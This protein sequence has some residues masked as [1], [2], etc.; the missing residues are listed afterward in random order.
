LGPG[1]LREPRRVGT[2][3]DEPTGRRELVELDLGFD[4][5]MRAKSDRRELQRGHYVVGPH[6]H[7]PAA[8]RLRG[9]SAVVLGEDFAHR[10]ENGLLAN[11]LRLVAPPWR[12][13]VQDVLLGVLLEYDLGSL[14]TAEGQRRL[15]L[16]IFGF[17]RSLAPFCG[18]SEGEP[19]EAKPSRLVWVRGR[20]SARPATNAA[21]AGSWSPERSSNTLAM[22][23]T[24]HRVES[25]E[26]SRRIGCK[27]RLENRMHSVN[28]VW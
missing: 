28:F 19:P 27:S 10:F 14:K 5:K 25:G 17:N 15:P 23:T 13:S 16:T 3:L 8:P 6:P 22:R 21:R 12:V 7:R 24:I 11:I 1:S 4:A 2:V 26:R 9:V 18:V 20:S